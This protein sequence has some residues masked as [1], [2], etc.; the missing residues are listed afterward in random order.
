MARAMPIPRA[1]FLPNV[2]EY[3]E[4][5]MALSATLGKPGGQK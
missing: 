4:C 1:S 5:R 3:A 2:L